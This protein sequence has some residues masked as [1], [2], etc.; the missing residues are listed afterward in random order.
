MQEVFEKIKQKLIFETSSNKVYKIINP[1]KEDVAEFNA[2]KKAIEIVD[3][4]AKEYN[5][6]WIP[7]S[8]RLPKLCEYV[9]VCDRDG[10][11]WLRWFKGD[12]WE[13]ASGFRDN[14]DKFIAWQPLPK[15]YKKEV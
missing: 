6:G 2:Y 13:L 11:P 3:E 5:N 4:V 10:H 7:C 8:E 15:P 14:L 9:L 1:N 12:Y